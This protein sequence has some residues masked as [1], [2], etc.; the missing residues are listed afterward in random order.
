MTADT[1]GCTRAHGE[2]AGGREMRGGPGG[3]GASRDPDLPPPALCKGLK[4]PHPLV[5]PPPG[6]VSVQVMP[7]N[8]GLYPP[9][10]F[11]SVRELPRVAVG[12][13]PRFHPGQK[14]PQARSGQRGPGSLLHAPAVAGASGRR[15]RRDGP[16]VG[17]AR[18]L[19]QG[20][21]GGWERV[22]GYPGVV[23]VADAPF[24]RKPRGCCPPTRPWRDAPGA[25]VRTAS[26]SP[27]CFAS[28]FLCGAACSEEDE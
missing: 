8:K 24:P 16:S 1:A 27:L 9:L 19:L 14:N 21:H 22:P 26:A 10:L 7:W 17:A 6:A 12:V 25:S 23:G 13:S 28:E 11:V 4:L 15:G 20:R 3:R 2:V 18:L 5:F